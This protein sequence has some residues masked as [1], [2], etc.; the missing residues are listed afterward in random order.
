MW[1]RSR[2]PRAASASIQSEQERTHAVRVAL[3]RMT[4]E[5]EMAYMSDNE[6]TAIANRR[7]LFV[8]VVARRRRRADVLHLR[9]PAPARG[10]R[11]RATPSLISY[12]GARDPDDRRI[13]NLMRR[14]TRRLQA[15]DPATLPGEAYIL[16]PDVSRVK[17]AF[18]DHKKKEWATDWSTLDA[19]GMPYLPTHVRITL[20]VI[21]ERGQEVSY[22]TDAR[23]QMTEKVGYRSLRRMSLLR[24]LH[25][26]RAPLN[27]RERGVAM[28]VVLTWLA[29]MISLVS[30]FT[31]GT[32]VDAAQAANARDELRAHYLARS[33]VNLSRL[34]IKIQQKFIDPVDGRR[35][36][37]C[38]SRRMGGSNSARRRRRRSRRPGRAG[39]QPARHRL[40]RAADGL[41]Q[42]VEGGGRRPRQPDRHRHRRHQGP[43]PQVGQLRRGDHLRGR[44]DRHRLRRRASR[45][46]ATGSSP[47]TGC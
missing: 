28:L 20:T 17:F 25:P 19:S 9:A 46:T 47:S 5:I 37:R 11:R 12:F 21:D 40:R 33:A 31:Y 14:E 44:Q 45:P 32:T 18:Y 26:R 10:R 36:S 34:L 35:R 4:R 13:L 41:L 38:C 30:E 29:L 22:S 23:I 43:G 6:N 8:G 27:R 16:C 1:G 2:R 3:M 7:T 42:R 24:R 39:L 15:E